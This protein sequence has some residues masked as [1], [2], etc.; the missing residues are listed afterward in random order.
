MLQPGTIFR[1]D[2][3][4]PLTP[5]EK[6]TID[7]LR[8][9]CSCVLFRTKTVFPFDF[10]PDDLVIDS[11]KVSVIIRD[12][13][14]SAQ[15]HSVPIKHISDLSV[16]HSLF[17][18]TLHILPGRVFQNQVMSIRHLK[19]RDAIRARNIIQGLIIADRENVAVDSI[20]HSIEGIKELEEM[21]RPF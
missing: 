12:F 14:G 6:Q 8:G 1:R 15:I 13:F 9:K 21:G 10:F 7:H 4:L 5:S 11:E 2:T 16:D 18:A 3:S 20:I 19:K 17:F